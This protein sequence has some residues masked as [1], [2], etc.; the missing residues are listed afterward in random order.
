MIDPINIT[1]YNLTDAE[2]EEHI[3][4]W[5][6]AAGK[7]GVTAAKC[8]DDLLTRLLGLAID[9]T[10]GNL[11]PGA[12]PFQLIRY[13]N[14]KHMRYHLKQAG[15]GCYKMKA[16]AFVELAHSNINLRTCT[17]KELEGITGIGPKTARCFIMHS[18]PDQQ[19]AGL[20]VHIL[21]FLADQGY[22]APK[23]TPTGKKYQEVESWFLKEVAASGMSVADFDL[24]IWNE[25]RNK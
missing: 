21:K 16:S 5:V 22:D 19:V 8:L 6:C 25:Y 20:D 14:V 9:M 12:T 18:R 10:K 4:F 17:L 1:N 2:L 23:V 15:I 13:H 24:K 11:L 3:L 7:N